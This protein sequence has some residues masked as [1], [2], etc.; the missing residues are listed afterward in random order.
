[1][2]FR[3]TPFENAGDFVEA[4]RDNRWRDIQRC[5]DGV[6]IALVPGARVVSFILY[7]TFVFISKYLNQEGTKIKY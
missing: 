6:F 4:L 7:S 3:G 5:Q 2:F 1:M